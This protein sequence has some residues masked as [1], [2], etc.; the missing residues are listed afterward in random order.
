MYPSRH[1][2]IMFLLFPGIMF[3]LFPGIMFLL[4]PGIMYRTWHE[5]MYRTWHEG[6]VPGMS[7]TVPGM[8]GYRTWHEGYRT[9]HCWDIS[10]VPHVPGDILG[11]LVGH[12]WDS[13]SNMACFLG[14][15][16]FLRDS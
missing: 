2:V 16:L 14:F 15:L 10:G 7:G 12:L 1:P 3:L 11:F 8:R 4:F 6:T 13:T 9:W 5:Y